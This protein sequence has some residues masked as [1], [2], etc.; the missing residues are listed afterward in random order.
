MRLGRIASL[1]TII[2][3]SILLSACREAASVGSSAPR[4]ETAQTKAVLV[5]GDADAAEPAIGSDKEGN[6]YVL[7]IAHAGDSAAD[8]YLQKFDTEL[9]PVG[10]KVRINPLEGSAKA[11]RGDPPTIGIDGN[12]T[13]YIGWTR[14]YADPDVT[15]NDLMVSVSRNSGHSFDEPVKVNDDEKPAS[16][17]MH[18]LAVG[19]DGRVYITWLDGRN[20]PAEPHHMDAS[21]AR[22]HHGKAEPNSELF[23]AISGDGG[24]TFSANKKIA[25]EV[26]P[27]CKTSM[28]AAPDGTIYVSWRQVLA[29]DHR[30]VAVAHSTDQGATFSDGVIVSDDNW[31]INACPVSGASLAVGGDNNALSVMWYTA[32]EAGQAGMYLCSSR[33]GGKTFGPRSLISADAMSGTPK[34]D[35]GNGD[36][37]FMVFPLPGDEIVAGAWDTVTSRLVNKDTITQAS[38]PT[39]AVGVNGKL[40][41]A[42]LRG[43]GDKRSVMLAAAAN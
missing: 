37:L 40:V 31:V 28:A 42:F 25:N 12:G 35:S 17:G 7:Y 39:A 33:D 4:V 11:W 34:V 19:G 24:K 21:A 16:H 2:V 26:C 23:Y 43:K 5:S 14:R 30:H 1:L 38:L 27:C 22:M 32:G 10:G 20:A 29:G 36:Q 8:L 6:L 41:T 18:S 3:I 13:I 15:G 9:K